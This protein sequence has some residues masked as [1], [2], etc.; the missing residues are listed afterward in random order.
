M[1]YVKKNIIIKKKKKNAC[2]SSSK[3]LEMDLIFISND[4]CEKVTNYLAT[5]SEYLYRT[6]TYQNRDAYEDVHTLTKIK[7]IDTNLG[8][9]GNKFT[10][11]FHE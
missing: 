11:N 2:L 8:F 5:K 10:S 7:Y 4:P 1:M 3:N 6:N 9:G